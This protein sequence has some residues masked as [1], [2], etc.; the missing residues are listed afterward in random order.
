MAS[1]P[2]ACSLTR[3][4][5]LR[6][7]VQTSRGM[8]AVGGGMQGLSYGL[9]DEA[10]A[11]AGYLEGGPEMANLRREQARAQLQANQQEFPV[12]G[13]AAE[14][15][16]AIASPISRVA[17]LAM[18]PAKL[19]GRILA[20]AAVGGGLGA[21][22]GFGSGEGLEGRTEGAIQQGL[23][24][25]G[26]GA[27][28][29]AI[30]AGGRRVVEN[31]ADGRKV[32]AAMRA[33]PAADE[34]QQRASAIY[35][36]ADETGPI[37]SR[38]AFGE[39]VGDVADRANRAGMDA[40]LTPGAARVMDRLQTAADD[41]NPGIGFREMDILRRKAAVPAGN[42]ANR[43]EQS[44]A[45]QMIDRID[46]FVANA[47]ANV[48]AQ[49]KE[50]REMW[51]I[52]RRSEK[53]SDAIA[54]ATDTASGFENGL[55][56]EFRKILNNPKLR[57]GF[58][59][60]E[61]NAIQQVVRGTKTGNLMRQLGRVGIG[62]SGQSNGLGAAVGAIGGSLVG[63]PVGSVVVPALGTAAKFA[64]ER[65]TRLAADRALQMVAARQAINAIPR[66]APSQ[67]AAGA[68]RGLNALGFGAL[69]QASAEVRN[70]LRLMPQ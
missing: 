30:A 28:I 36:Q 29:P 37:A 5:L 15:A 67:I 32:K 41:L 70:W 45:S 38:A 52:L 44:I 46:D 14:F 4:E 43:P 33:A 55:R 51:G 61:I 10:M 18:M 64:A 26:I 68:E 24:G 53:V 9:G 62:I 21:A 60:D 63:G 3:R 11:I 58:S 47:D 54:K 7:N 49:V 39:F 40:D 12:T 25:A 17:N 42:V 66:N 23:F 31:F 8:A 50:A 19:G 34:L 65:T 59:K 22:Y 6:N 2:K 48:G 20:G 35:Q 16:G 27:A 1:R 13:A 69:P 57:R 56:I